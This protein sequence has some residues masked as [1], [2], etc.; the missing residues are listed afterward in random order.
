M[1]RKFPEYKNFDL[2]Q[3]NKEINDLWKSEQTFERSLSSREGKPSFVFYE[4]PPSANGVPGNPP[5]DGTRHQ[6]YFLPF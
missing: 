3:I 2:S 1:A 5:R 4:G 6:R